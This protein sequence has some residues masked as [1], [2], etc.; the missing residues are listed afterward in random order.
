MF[1][2]VRRKILNIKYSIIRE[3]TVIN[4]IQNTLSKK[5]L[6]EM[7]TCLITSAEQIIV[8]Y[9]FLFNT[10]FAH[11]IDV[12]IP[13]TDTIIRYNESIFT[14][15][16]ESLNTILKTGRKDIETFAK[17]K[18]YLD[19]YFLSVTTKGILKYQYKKNYLLNL[20]DICQELSVS[21][22]T[23]NRY[24]RLGLEEVTGEDGIS[25]LYPKHNTF[26]FK[27]AL[28]ALEIQGLNQDFII[29]NRSTQ[30]TKEYLLGEIKVFEERYGTTFKDFVKATSNPDELDK[31]LDYHTWQHLEEE[32]EKLK[33]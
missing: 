22:A 17:A 33:D 2:R 10:Q 4:T 14:E 18:Y 25:K 26:Y 16:Y 13:S 9:T 30:E 20:Q 32:L 29:R 1:I 28:W 5:L 27:D 23:L 3:R 7:S 11:L 21:S 8:N 19:T 12:V 24:V 31:P 6:E 15:E